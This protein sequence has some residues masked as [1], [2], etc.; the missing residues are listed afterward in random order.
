MLGPGQRVAALMDDETLFFLKAG[1]Y[2]KRT[3]RFFLVS[4]RNV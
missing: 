4:P 2:P 3:R 1:R